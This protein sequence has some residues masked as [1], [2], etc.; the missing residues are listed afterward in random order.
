MDLVE[1]KLKPLREEYKTASPQ[2]RKEIL[3]EVEKIKRVANDPICSRQLKCL[4]YAAELRE[5]K[6]KLNPWEKEATID[7]ARLIFNS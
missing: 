5:K 2:R 4:E 1:E 3:L 6:R 7:E